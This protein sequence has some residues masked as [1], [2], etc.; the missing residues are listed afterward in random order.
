MFEELVV[1]FEFLA[2][3][4]GSFYRAVANEARDRSMRWYGWLELDR[5]H[6]S[7]DRLGP[8]GVTALIAAAGFRQ[9]D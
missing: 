6:G 2:H 7:G 4:D 5:R 1:G 9:P 8:E 3:Q